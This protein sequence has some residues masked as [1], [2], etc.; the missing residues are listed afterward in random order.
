[1]TKYHPVLQCG[2]HYRIIFILLLVSGLS[3]PR[4]DAR[5]SPPGAPRKRPSVGLVLSGGGAKGF[6]YVGLLRV[7]Q[8]AG[9]PI[10]Y[11]GG[12]SIGSI[13]DCRSWDQTSARE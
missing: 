13:I 4:L 10:D 6:A 3:A 7:I 12:S 2:I 9:L 8:E 1:M 11:I 5:Q